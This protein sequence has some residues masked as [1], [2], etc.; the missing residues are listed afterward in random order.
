MEIKEAIGKAWN[1]VVAKFMQDTENKMSYHWNEEVLMLHFFRF[2]NDTGAK[3]RQVAS[4]E[5]FVFLKKNYEPDFVF[6][7]ET[8]G[9]VESAVLE[10]KMF[11]RKREELEEDWRRLEKFRE[12]TFDG[13]YVNYGYL[14][15]FTSF[16]FKKDV[17]RINDYEMRAITYRVPSNL[18]VG[19]I[20]EVAQSLMRKVFRKWQPKFDIDEN[21]YPFAFFTDHAVHFWLLKDIHLMLPVIIFYNGE[22]LS[23]LTEEFRNRGYTNEMLERLEDEGILF[24]SEEPFPV[25][26]T[27]YYIAKIRRL[28][29]GFEEDYLQVKEE[30]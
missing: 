7:V 11:W 21:G 25:R 22:K 10:F 2:L 29:E 4:K 16:D 8:N 13:K 9:K 15:A 12:I 14:L 30:L 17:T 3:I 23:K 28:Y 5:R 18:L 6:S 26:L 1:M 27:P 24:L 20:T 19:S